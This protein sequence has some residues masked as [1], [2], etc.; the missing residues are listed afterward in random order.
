MGQVYECDPFG[1]QQ[2]RVRPALGTFK[3]EAA[4]VDTVNQ[5]LYLT[6]DVPDGGFYRFR[7][8]NGL[9]DLSEGQLEI[10]SVMEK[11]KFE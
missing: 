9:P 5:C 11:V 6:E 7:P 4:A 10:A 8:T 2:A 3:H 1:I